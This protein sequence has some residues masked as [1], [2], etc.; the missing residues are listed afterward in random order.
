M[1]SQGGAKFFGREILESITKEDFI[2]KGFAFDVELIKRVSDK[3]YQ[4]EEVF[5][6]HK[7][8]RESKF[9]VG[10]IPEM[11]MDVLKIRLIIK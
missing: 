1:D 7:H 9:S 4:V 11:L 6:P 10:N 8:V 2:S 5:V 3:G